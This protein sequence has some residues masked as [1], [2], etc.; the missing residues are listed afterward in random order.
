MPLLNVLTSEGHPP[1]GGRSDGKGGQLPEELPESDIRLLER[2]SL[3]H[4]QY[5]CGAFHPPFGG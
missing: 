4:R 1:R 3:Q 5:H 2:R